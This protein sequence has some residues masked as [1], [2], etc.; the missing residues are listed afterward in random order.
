M[1]SKQE[2]IAILTS[3]GEAGG[4]FADFFGKEEI[5]QM[6]QNIQNDFPIEFETKFSETSTRHTNEIERLC[7]IML[8]SAHKFSDMNLLKEVIQIRGH[9]WVIKY[10]LHHKMTLWEIDEQYIA[11]NIR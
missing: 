7:K 6:K 4:Y 9:Q 5:E 10:K 11:E 1:I 8:E 2:E 3:L